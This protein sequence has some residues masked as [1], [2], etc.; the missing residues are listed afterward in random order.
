MIARESALCQ[1][2]PWHRAV[3]HPKPGDLHTGQVA[4]T[5]VFGQQA[6]CR[7]QIKQPSAAIEGYSLAERNTEPRE[8]AR[9]PAA[10]QPWSTLRAGTRHTRHTPSALKCAAITHVPYAGRERVAQ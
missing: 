2:D 4:R 7:I 6:C 5:V 3:R 10:S 1:A 9:T 8:D